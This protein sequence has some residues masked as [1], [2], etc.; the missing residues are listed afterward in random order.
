MTDHKARPLQLHTIESL[1]VDL[2][3]GHEIELT[4]GELFSL[5]NLDTRSILKWYYG[6][7]PKWT[8]RNS[9]ADIE[10]LADQVGKTVAP[11]PTVGA[12]VQSVKK[13]LRLVKIEA[14]RFAGI[15]SYG[16]REIAP[17][18][19]VF[20][21]QHKFFF[22]FL[23]WLC[24]D[25]FPE[26]RNAPAASSNGSRGWSFAMLDFRS[27]K[28][29]LALLKFQRILMFDRLQGWFDIPYCVHQ[30]ATKSSPRNH[31]CYNSLV[32]TI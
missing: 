11:L 13:Y 29:N 14:H 30:A 20:E 23:W 2:I 4:D 3:N 12:P 25:T 18:N 26:G 24:V 9:E 6:N 32:I 1:C 31:Y 7:K 17:E 21:P 10:S 5:N 28:P 15:H 16:S 19:F 22:A 27:W 8:A